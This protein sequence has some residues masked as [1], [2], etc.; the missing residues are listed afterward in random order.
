MACR[1]G[2]LELPV[3]KEKRK[4]ELIILWLIAAIGILAIMWLPTLAVY[5]RVAVAEWGTTVL[6]VLF[7]SAIL[8]ACVKEPPRQLMAALLIAVALIW[9][10]SGANRGEFA[11]KLLRRLSRAPL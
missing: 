1:P 4:D 10:P 7:L 2:A 9:L 11:A 3:D 6:V 5:Y 8:I